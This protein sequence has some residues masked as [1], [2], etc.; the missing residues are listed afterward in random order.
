LSISSN[1][2]DGQAS[3]S[4]ADTGAG[5]DPAATEQLFTALYTTKGEGLGLGLSICRKI[6]GAHG[7]R[8]WAE[9]NAAHGAT[10]TFTLPLRRSFPV[11][12]SN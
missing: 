2:V 1:V 9:K 6:V 8:L 10:F 4:V 3:V 7:G 11:P 5:I 12:R